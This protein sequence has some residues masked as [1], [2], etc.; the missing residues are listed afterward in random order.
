[1]WDPP[2]HTM[3]M[4]HTIM[5]LVK[6]TFPE[7][8]FSPIVVSSFI[9]MFSLLVVSTCFILKL[10]CSQTETPTMNFSTLF[11]E[12]KDN[13]HVNFGE[14]IKRSIKTITKNLRVSICK[15]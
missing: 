1:M 8:A 7:N 2:A 14:L 6:P 12:I 10:V 11:L 4:I 13:L 5:L 3:Q 15:Q 9:I